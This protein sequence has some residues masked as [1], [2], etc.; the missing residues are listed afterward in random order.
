MVV[1]PKCGR[2]CEETEK[3]CAHCNADLQSSF[4][5]GD[6]N[7]IVPG[8]T[9]KRKNNSIVVLT[10]VILAVCTLLISAAVCLMNHKNDNRTVN[11]I[12]WENAEEN[13]SICP[14]ADGTKTIS[15]LSPDYSQILLLIAQ[16][17]PEQEITANLLKKAIAAH[18][19]L[20]TTY[21]FQVSN[22][23]TETIQTAFKEAI[24]KE[25]LIL[26]ILEMPVNDEG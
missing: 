21:S 10:A 3:T 7:G 17:N 22:T 18:P 15:V 24:V 6:V 25:M 9:A 13:V 23:E 2:T 8:S 4:R 11:E 12:M 1:C 14:N 26:S 5:T 19:E 16:E 20:K